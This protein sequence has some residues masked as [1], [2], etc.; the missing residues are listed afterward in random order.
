MLQILSFGDHQVS[1]VATE[2]QARTIGSRLRP[3]GGGPGPA[4]GRDPYFGIPRIKRLPYDGNASL[5]VWDIGPLRPPGAAPRARPNAW[6]PRRRRP[7]T[8]RR[9][10]A[11]IPTTW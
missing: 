5:V 2:V 3:P 1:N 7:P 6:A 9:A 10:S 8:R 11:W 4:H